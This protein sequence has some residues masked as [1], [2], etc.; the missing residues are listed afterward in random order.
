MAFF[1][2]CLTWQHYLRGGLTWDQARAM[3]M[4]TKARREQM[5]WFEVDDGPR[6]HPD[7]RGSTEGRRDYETGGKDERRRK[8]TREV[9][10]H[11]GDKESKKKKTEKKEKKKSKKSKR[12][13]SPEPVVRGGHHKRPPPDGGDKA[14]RVRQ[15]AENTWIVTCR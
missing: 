1:L 3:A 13:P 14:P 5:D 2:Y 9:K 11:K 12:S 15:V 7:A 4:E 10:S 6:A 8:K